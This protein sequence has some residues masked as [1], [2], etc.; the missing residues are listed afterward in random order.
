MYKLLQCGSLENTDYK[1]RG[2]VMG[3]QR[4]D[5]KNKVSFFQSIRTK[6]SVLVFISLLITS[7]LIIVIAVEVSKSNSKRITTNYMKDMAASYG[8][9]VEL[10]IFDYGADRAEAVL[11]AALA[12]AVI[13]DVESSYTYAVGGDGTM[14]YHPTKEKIG[15]PVENEAVIDLVERI[16]SGEDLAMKC[17]LIEYEFNGATK[18]ASY[19]VT[20]DQSMIIVV[21]ADEADML[22]SVNKMAGY[23]AVVG[24]ICILVC[25]IGAI[26]ITYRLVSP[27]NKLTQLV[28][29]ITDLDLRE[30][31]EEKVLCRR[32][33]ETGVMSRGISLMRSRLFNVV[34]DMKEQSNTLY[35]ASETLN[36]NIVDVNGS[37]E[38]VDQAVNEIAEG[39]TSQAADTQTA[40]ENVVTIGSM[41]SETSEKIDRLKDSMDAIKESNSVIVETIRDLDRI[42]NQTKE[43]IAN[44]SEQTDVA[45][46]SAQKIRGVTEI[47]ASIAEETNLLSLNASIEAARAGEAGRGFAVVASQ[48]QK[49]AEQSNESA[50]QI[51]EISQQLIEDSKQTVS[52]MGEVKEIIFKQSENVEK[53]D[54]LFDEFSRK[55]VNAFEDID[56][57]TVNV[58]NMDKAR[59]TVVDVVQNLMAIAEENAASTEETGASATEVSAIINDIAGNVD[60]LVLVANKLDEDMKQFQL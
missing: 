9:V 36:T 58:Q 3:V 20:S 39:A 24:L 12:Q 30:T 48:I 1:N 13:K 57:I 28:A 19:Y 53:T 7:M 35:T 4:Q 10:M 38:Q 23:I 50:K 8:E 43:S 59:V 22:S 41:I 49:L 6:I 2:G 51:E 55:L 31:P 34:D 52:T 44:I 26:L 15:K 27:I 16:S 47:I 17:D 37:V 32:G 18:Y 14:L 45:N 33:D 21:T 56:N 54:K 5:N 60:K 11:E 40:T 25:S 29:R 46:Q 42:N